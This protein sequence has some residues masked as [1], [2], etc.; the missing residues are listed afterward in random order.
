VAVELRQVLPDDT[1]GEILPDWSDLTFSQDLLNPGS[2]SF[3]Y[4]VDG[5][6][7]SVLNHGA[8]LTTLLDGIEPINARFLFNEGSGSR[9]GDASAAVSTFGATSTLSRATKMLLGPAFLDDDGTPASSTVADTFAY[10]DKT[11]G[12]LLRTAIENSM[13]RGRQLSATP[14]EWLEFP[15]AT[16]TDDTDSSGEAWPETYDV[17]FNAGTT[18]Q[19]VID[20]LVNHGFAEAQMVGRELRLYHP[21]NNGRNLSVGSDPLVLQTGHDFIEASYQTTSLDLANALLVTG[22]DNACTWVYDQDSITRYGYREAVLQVP[23]ATQQS[24]LIAAGQAYLSTRKDPR[25][26]YTYSVSALYLEKTSNNPRPFIDYQVGDSLLVLDGNATAVQRLR[27]LS[28]TWPSAR[29]ATVNI[30]VNDLLAERDV[31]FDRRLQ[32]LGA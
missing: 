27:L 17:T 28:A 16:F 8:C 11:A 9:L 22:D 3:S 2:L 24:T 19:D 14:Q 29:S 12:W 1:Y 18:V 5:R 31:E 32:R 21:S 25:Y 4:P 20:W 13:S 7:A 15:L 10:T 6:N 26:S 23:N 30:T